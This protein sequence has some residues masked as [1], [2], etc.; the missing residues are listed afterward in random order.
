MHHFHSVF[1]SPQKG[2]H[3]YSMD[4]K[5]LQDEE[6]LAHGVD[7]NPAFG[8]YLYSRRTG[9]VLMR[10]GQLYVLKPGRC[11]LRY[12]A[13]NEVLSGAFDYYRVDGNNVDFVFDHAVDVAG[14]GLSSP[15]RL[16]ARF[17]S[18]VAFKFNTLCDEHLF[19]LAIVDGG[20]RL[21]GQRSPYEK[22][23]LS[24]NLKLMP[25]D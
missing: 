8:R 25:L 24:I 20:V 14:L 19:Q 15:V 5:T 16:K 18:A 11:Q 13:E 6:S 22:P 23:N 3:V 9:Q 1:S 10:T 2:A 17:E 21:L 4:G 12:R 7:G